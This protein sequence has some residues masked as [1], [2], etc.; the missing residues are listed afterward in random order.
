MP[1]TCLATVLKPLL[2]FNEVTSSWGRAISVGAL[3]FCLHHPNW[4]PEISRSSEESQHIWHWP[5]HGDW[6][7]MRIKLHLV[8][9]QFP[10]YDLTIFEGLGRLEEAILFIVPQPPDVCRNNA[11]VL[12]FLPRL[13]PP[14]END[15][16]TK[17]KGC[18]WCL[19]LCC[20]CARGR[21]CCRWKKLPE[22]GYLSGDRYT[23]DSTS[24][25]SEN[26]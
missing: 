9:H 10:L 14:F 23:S 15:G 18:H 16:V 11:L 1:H 21:I 12:R 17:T 19:C 22:R 20:G 26:K 2:S 5:L 13:L 25:L 7:G 8:F 24:M 4:S 3:D 6:Y